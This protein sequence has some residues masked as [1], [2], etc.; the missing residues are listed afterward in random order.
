MSDGREVVR[1]EHSQRLPA[2]VREGFDYI[3]DL[4]NWHEYWPGLVRLEPGSQWS[5]PGDRA[6]L[7]LRLLGRETEM[8]MVLSRIDPYRLV[9]YTSEQP[10]FPDAHHGRY[11]ADDGTG[12]LEYRLLVEYLPRRGLRGFFD[13]VLFRRAVKRALGETAANLD[14]RL[15][16]GSPTQD[17]GGA[18][19]A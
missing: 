3:T 19:S 1:V 6:R 5:E 12:G 13:R 15:R 10:G 2:T 18:P 7:V 4:R 8:R 17:L 11:F 14:A 9:E 16:V